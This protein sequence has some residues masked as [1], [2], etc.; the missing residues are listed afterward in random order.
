MFPLRLNK[1]DAMKA[2]ETFPPNSPLVGVVFAKQDQT[3]IKDDAKN[4]GV[5]LVTHGCNAQVRGLTRETQPG[6]RGREGWTNEKPGNGIKSRVRTSTRDWPTK[7]QLWTN[8]EP[9]NVTK[10]RENVTPRYWMTDV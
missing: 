8:K 9:R 7:E 10:R 5:I 6:S 1:V 4:R 3:C 2:K